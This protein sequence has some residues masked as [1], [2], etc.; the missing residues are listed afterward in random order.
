[1]AILKK[2]LKFFHWHKLQEINRPIGPYDIYI[3][4]CERGLNRLALDDPKGEWLTDQELNEY[5]RYL[6]FEKKQKQ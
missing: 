2:I 1:M 3:E 6:F 4:R 5:F